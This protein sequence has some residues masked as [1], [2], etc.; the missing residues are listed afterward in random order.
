VCEVK[1]Y[2]LGL[3]DVWERQGRQGEQGWAR[4]ISGPVPNFK[5]AKC[6]EL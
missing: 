3:Y 6:I 2:T 5:H 4:E 1:L